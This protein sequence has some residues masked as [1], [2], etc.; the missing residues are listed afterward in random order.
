MRLADFGKERG[1]SVELAI[2]FVATNVIGG[3]D[4]LGGPGSFKLL[5]QKV[6]HGEQRKRFGQGWICDH[7][8]FLANF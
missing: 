8:N 4:G 2:C 5:Q 7:V 6:Q 1:L 3:L